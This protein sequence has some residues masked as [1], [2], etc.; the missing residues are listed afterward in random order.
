MTNAYFSR[1]R[2]MSGASGGFNSSDI[3]MCSAYNGVYTVIVN[4][5]VSPDNPGFMADAGGASGGTA[6]YRARHHIPDVHME[7]YTNVFDAYRPRFR[8]GLYLDYQP[9]SLKDA[10]R[11]LDEQDGWR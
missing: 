2:L 9:T 7:L 5:A 6:R 3:E 1:R 8:P 4:N 10:K 11:Y